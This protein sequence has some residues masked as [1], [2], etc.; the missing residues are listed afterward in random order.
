MKK[1]IKYLFGYLAVYGMF[2][3]IFIKILIKLGVV[4]F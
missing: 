4:E 2:A 1:F 3:L